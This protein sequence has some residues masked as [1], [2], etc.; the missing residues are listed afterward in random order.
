MDAIGSSFAL[1]QQMLQMQQMQL[2]HRKNSVG[3]DIS[4]GKPP[5]GSLIISDF[6]TP[7]EPG[8]KFSHGE[9]VNMAARQNGFR[10]PVFT[11]DQPMSSMGATQAI[12]S[13]EMILT[14]PSANREDILRAVSQRTNAQAMS[15]VE[16]QTQAVK[17]ATASGAKN[18]VLNLSMGGS[19]AGYATDL[20]SQA[21]L[22]WDDK[23]S[24]DNRAY[25]ATVAGNF[26]KAYDLNMD[27]LQSTDPKISGPERAKLQQNL[28]KHVDHTIENSSG[29]KTA[30][31]A[32]TTEVRRFESGNN[33]VVISAGNHA[34]DSNDM[35]KDA[36]GTPVMA[37]KDY[38]KNLLEIP[39]VTSVGATRFMD[40]KGGVKERTAQYSSRSEGVDIY[41][42]GSVDY[43]GDQKA[44][45]W[46]TSFSAPR[47]AGTMAELH[48]QNPS[49]TSSQIENLMR[50]RLT[51]DLNSGSGQIQVLDYQKSS[52]FLVGRKG[53]DQ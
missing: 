50:N 2:Q 23:A 13:A 35:I 15:L 26:A 18:S 37:P 46:G 25:G 43:D 20:Y 17:N 3:P 47:V 21:S 36:A 4:S 53:L 44:D 34:D 33:S 11:A 28:I 51:H 45:N 16:T 22:A 8:D 42:S 40:D 24:A 9:V 6:F 48:R 29:L 49:M 5:A 27:S 31:Q 30:K 32:Y 12:S 10:G 1:E 14:D 39:E 41:A 38:E 7:S 52:D 19:K